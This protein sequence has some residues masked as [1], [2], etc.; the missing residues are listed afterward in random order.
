[1]NYINNQNLD[2]N[3]Y[4]LLLIWDDGIASQHAFGGV[5]TIFVTLNYRGMLLAYVV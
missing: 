1:M 2:K 4:C 5:G 3:P